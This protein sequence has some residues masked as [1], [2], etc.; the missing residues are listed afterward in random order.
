LDG[1]GI[2]DTG[3]NFIGRRRQEGLL[4]KERGF[5]GNLIFG[6]VGINPS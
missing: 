1:K 3:L 5:Q 2:K 4:P 6:G